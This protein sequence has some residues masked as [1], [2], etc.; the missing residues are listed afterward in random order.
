MSSSEDKKRE[1]QQLEQQ[2]TEIRAALRELG[3]PNDNEPPNQLTIVWQSVRTVLYRYIS[4]SQIGY[5]F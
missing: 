5:H 1:I 3:T 4:F 2:S